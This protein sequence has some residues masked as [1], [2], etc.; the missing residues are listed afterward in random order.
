MEFTGEL[1]LT[2][3]EN[4]QPVLD[5]L[6]VN[7]L[8]KLEGATNLVPQ[9][10]EGAD[11]QY[12]IYDSEQSEDTTDT[13]LVVASLSTEDTEQ[14]NTLRSLYRKPSGSTNFEEVDCDG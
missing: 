4:L 2:D 10:A 9:L 12:G 13:N 8:D 11:V 14:V 5:L 3:E 1:D 7:P 6:S